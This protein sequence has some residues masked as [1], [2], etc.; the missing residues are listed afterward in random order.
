MNDAGGFNSSRSS[1][2]NAEP[3]IK[4]TFDV[5]EKKFHSEEETNAEHIT[6]NCF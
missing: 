1:C 5:M 6:R 2:E 4:Y 3:K